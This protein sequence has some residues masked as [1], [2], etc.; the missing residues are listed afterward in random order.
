M[1]DYHSD[2]GFSDVLLKLV[3]SYEESS[4]CTASWSQDSQFDSLSLISD[5][6]DTFSVFRHGDIHT[7]LHLANVAH[8]ETLLL[9]HLCTCADKTL[10]W[11]FIHSKATTAPGPPATTNSFGFIATSSIE[12]PLFRPSMSLDVEDLQQWAFQAHL[13]VKSTNVYNYKMPGYVSPLNC[14]L[15]IGELFV[16]IITTK[17]F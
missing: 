16:E 1:V 2:S 7:S 11:C 13:M 8:D 3:N 4:D 6:N 5:I 9:K 14:T 15:I 17:K 12:F 10:R